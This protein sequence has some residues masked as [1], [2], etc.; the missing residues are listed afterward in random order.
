[1]AADPNCLCV[2]THP[3]SGQLYSGGERKGIALKTS[4]LPNLR[5]GK[6]CEEYRI[7]QKSRYD[8]SC[9]AITAVTVLW[10]AHKP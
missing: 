1:M 3:V 5:G 6:V 9:L 2:Q 8:G 4:M 10:T 7:Y